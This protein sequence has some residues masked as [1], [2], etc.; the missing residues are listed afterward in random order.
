MTKKL[1]FCSVFKKHYARVS[2]ACR[3]VNVGGMSMKIEQMLETLYRVQKI[4]PKTPTNNG[5]LRVIIGA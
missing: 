2:S 3:C 5:I 1:K 4:E